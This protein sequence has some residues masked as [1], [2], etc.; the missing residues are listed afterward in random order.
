[1]KVQVATLVLSDQAYSPFTLHI[2]DDLRGELLGE[3]KDLQDE[4]RD[5]VARHLKRRLGW[6]PW[7]F[8]V[9]EDSDV[10]GDPTRPHAHGS[11]LIPRVSLD[12]DGVKVPRRWTNAVSRM[13]RDQAELLE[14][15]RVV[16]A[17]LKAAAGIAGGRPKVALSSGIDQS[18]NVWFRRKPYH[19]VFNTQ[20]VDYAFKNT[21]RASQTLGDNRL[22][23]VNGLRAEAERLW[24]LIRKGESALASWDLGGSAESQLEAEAA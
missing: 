6:V 14:G 24:E 2:H 12:R 23:M 19:T 7:F 15:R 11:I 9:M 13:G 17:A 20:W 8:F 22:V 21:K 18:R 4:L 1:M 3:G 10:Y 16:R 5:R